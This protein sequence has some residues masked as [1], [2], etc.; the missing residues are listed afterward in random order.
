MCDPDLEPPQV[1]RERWRTARKEHR[2]CACGERIRPRTRYQ[3]ISGIW[4]GEPDSHKR[5][6]RCVRISDEIEA[7]RDPYDPPAAIALDCGT[8]WEDAFG[9]APPDDVA[10]LAFALPGELNRKEET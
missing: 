10:A 2:C 1:Y 8:S 3:Y 9:A 4:D 7:R 5:C 6:E